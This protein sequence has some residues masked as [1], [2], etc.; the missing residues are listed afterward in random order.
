MSVSIASLS[1]SNVCKQTKPVLAWK[2]VRDSRR[3]QEQTDC[4]HSLGRPRIQKTEANPNKADIHE[5]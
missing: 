1:F 4:G 5:N 2:T 3:S